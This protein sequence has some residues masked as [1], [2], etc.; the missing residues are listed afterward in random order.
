MWICHVKI[1]PPKKWCGD[2]RDKVARYLGNTAR[3]R[4]SERIKKHDF[5]FLL[6]PTNL[7]KKYKC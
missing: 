4:R 7:N 3:H 6:R 2:A 1:G 5:T